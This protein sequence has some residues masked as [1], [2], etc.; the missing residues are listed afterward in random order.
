M[1]TLEKLRQFVA[2]ALLHLSTIVLSILLWGTQFSLELIGQSTC[3]KMQ[4]H[5]SVF[6]FFFFSKPSI[7][8]VSIHAESFVVKE[9]DCKNI[10]QN[11]VSVIWLTKFK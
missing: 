1:L 6:F 7:L 3:T 2:I 9:E 5:F 10:V 8:F 11:V 4:T